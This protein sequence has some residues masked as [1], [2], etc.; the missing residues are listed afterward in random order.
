[1][2]AWFIVELILF[3]GIICLAA[4]PDVLADSTQVQYQFSNISGNEWSYTYTVTSTPLTANEAFT[5]FFTQGLYSNLQK[6][7]PSPDGWSVFSTQPVPPTTLNTPGQYTALAL[8]D[9]ASLT[10]PFMITFD[11]SGAG[12]PGSQDFSIDRFDANGNLLNNVTTGVTTP[13]AQ[14]V[15]EPATGLLLLVGA[16]AASG[17]RKRYC[18]QS[19]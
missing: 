17:L 7:P 19:S 12:T 15:P 3:A 16:A 1:M 9:G 2:R 11:Y 13:F 14:Q 5:V 6:Q 18:G 10:G 8:N 4:T